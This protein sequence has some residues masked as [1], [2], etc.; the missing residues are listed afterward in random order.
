[1]NPAYDA[2]YGAHQRFGYKTCADH[3]EPVNEV[4]DAGY[5]NLGRGAASS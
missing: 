5:V 3:Y 1:M 4:A 2:F